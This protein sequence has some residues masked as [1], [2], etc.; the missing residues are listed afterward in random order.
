MV[1]VL[2]LTLVVVVSACIPDFGEPVD[3]LHRGVLVSGNGERTNLLRSGTSTVVFTGAPWDNDAGA[4]LYW[5]TESTYFTDLQACTSWYSTARSTF[6]QGPAQPGIALRIAPGE[7]DGT[8]RAVTVSERAEIDFE[9]V[10]IDMS[11]FDVDVWDTAEPIAPSTRIASF[12][13]S[14]VVGAISVDGPNPGDTMRAP[15]WHVCARTLGEELTL[16]VWVRDDPEPSWDDPVHVFRTTLPASA[17]RSGYAGHF[18]S[19]MHANQ[20]MTFG[21]LSSMPTCLSPDLAGDPVCATAG[22][23]TNPGRPGASIP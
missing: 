11:H 15:P 6:D 12:D 2:F 5:S 3:D 18:V 23:D 20:S 10:S 13:L 4:E 21:P 16:K 19:S 8:I 7:V 9:N 17:T 22:G 1:G 14:A